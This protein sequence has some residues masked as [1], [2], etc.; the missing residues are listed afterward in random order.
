MN[1][2]RGTSYSIWIF[3]IIRTCI[4]CPWFV[5]VFKDVFLYVSGVYDIFL[6]HLVFSKCLSLHTRCAFR[7][8]NL[9]IIASHQ[10]GKYVGNTLNDRTA[11]A[12]FCYYVESHVVQAYILVC[13]RQSV[14]E[15]VQDNYDIYDICTTGDAVMKY[16]HFVF[17]CS[18]KIA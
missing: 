14:L 10:Y 4:K 2:F 1:R 7:S 8:A 3:L 12:R 17:I 5:Y 15:N 11:L 9:M 16:V 13:I 6:L 18:L